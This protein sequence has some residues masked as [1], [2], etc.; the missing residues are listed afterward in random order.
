MVPEQYVWLLG[1]ILYLIPWG[2][3]YSSYPQFRHPML[4]ASVFT[5][6]FGLAEPI[7][8][9][10]YRT[11]ASVFDLLS[12][13]GF[14]LES[15]FFYFVLG[16]IAAAL[17]N[18]N[19]HKG[20]VSIALLDRGRGDYDVSP[21]TLA[22]PFVLFPLLYFFPWSPVYAASVALLIGALIGILYRLEFDSLAWMG[23]VIFTVYFLVFGWSLEWMSPGYLERLWNHEGIS[24]VR[25]LSIPLE[26]YMFAFA[27]GAY[28]TV[29]YEHFTWRKLPY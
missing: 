28:W 6:P 1:S 10:E 2:I 8:V 11:P 7:F 21:A 27:V 20:W 13:T 18:A 24:G 17:Y 4:W 16:G 22:G 25:I 14:D 12:K 29:V 3:L 19:L 9:P 23:G 15:L 26:E 5:M